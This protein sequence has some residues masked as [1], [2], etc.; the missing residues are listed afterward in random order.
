MTRAISALMPASSGSSSRSS[1]IERESDG[2]IDETPTKKFSRHAV[3]PKPLHLGDSNKDFSD[4]TNSSKSISPD[5]SQLSSA[6]SKLIGDGNVDP[7]ETEE[8]DWRPG[9]P[10]K[11]SGTASK[12]TS[13]SVSSASIKGPRGRPVR[14]KLS[15]PKKPSDKPQSAKS[16]SSKGADGGE[17]DADREKSPSRKIATKPRR[18]LIRGFERDRMRAERAKRASPRTSLSPTSANIKQSDHTPPVVGAEI[19]V[20]KVEFSQV[21]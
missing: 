9:C 17:Y 14:V 20:L 10:H 2:E 11:D 7:D 21:D 3:R 15:Q 18:R 13:P 1:S 4:N 5:P 12:N 6:L 19:N 16:D 8:E